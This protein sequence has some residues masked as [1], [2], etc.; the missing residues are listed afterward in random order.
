MCADGCGCNETTPDTWVK[1]WQT[2]SSF[3][4]IHGWVQTGSHRVCTPTYDGY[5]QCHN[6]D[7]YS[8]V[9]VQTFSDPKPVMASLG[10]ANGEVERAYWWQGDS[11]SGGGYTSGTTTV[12]RPVAGIP[13]CT[14]NGKMTPPL[15][16]IVQ[17]R[18]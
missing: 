5:Q 10:F 7:D 9:V 11:A 2:E 3:H 1:M 17:S 6:V 15:K 13:S 18:F 12:F 8:D 14:L 16:L 4:Q